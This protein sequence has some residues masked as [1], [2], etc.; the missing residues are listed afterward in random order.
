MRTAIVGITIIA[1][2]GGCSQEPEP[3]KFGIHEAL[4]LCLISYSR[5]EG[6]GG[7]SATMFTQRTATTPDGDT[8][9][10]AQLGCV[11]GALQITDASL[12]QITSTTLFSGT[13]ETA[14]GEFKARSAFTPTRGMQVTITDD[15]LN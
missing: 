11:L 14:W 10:M 6:D 1:A 9:T 3:K 15:T 13:Q 2:L 5:I 4:N 8:V 12:S 7:H